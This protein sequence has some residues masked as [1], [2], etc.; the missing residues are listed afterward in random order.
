[1]A[2][3]TT[4]DPNKP[5]WY[6]GFGLGAIVVG[7]LALAVLVAYLSTGRITTSNDVIG[8]IGGV[9]SPIVAMVSAYF[10]ITAAAKSQTESSANQKDTNDKA[11]QAV[12]A[13]NASAF[14]A[15]LNS[16]PGQ[17][18]T[19][20]GHAKAALDLLAAVPTSL[21]NASPAPQSGTK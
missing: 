3:T 17:A 11:F 18:E 2:S 10:G 15:A 7:V 1:M 16:D 13:A 8:V 20:L 21:P 4:A 12:S 14:A 19:I 9:A 5:W 6:Y